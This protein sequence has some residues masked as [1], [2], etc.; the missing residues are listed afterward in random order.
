MVCKFVFNNFCSEQFKQFK[1][2]D[3]KKHY[4]SFM[5]PLFFYYVSKLF[6]PCIPQSR[7]T[8][9]NMTCARVRTE[10]RRSIF[11]AECAFDSHYTP[12]DARDFLSALHAP[13]PT[14]LSF[15][16]SSRPQLIQAAEQNNPV[17][18]VVTRHGK[19]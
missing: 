12:T 4:K 16:R 10:I 6:D 15:G 9:Q 18:A 14:P 13:S 11:H 17:I 5:L 8:S 19:R 2:S 1:K 3:G 7:S